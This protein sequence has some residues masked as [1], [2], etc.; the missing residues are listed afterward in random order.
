MTQI[1]FTGPEPR[2][3]HPTDAAYDLHAQ[4]WTQIPPGG[5]ALV[6]T[7]SGIALPPGTVG[8]V[9]PRS[10]LALNHGVTVLN[11]PGVIDPGYTGE[12]GVIVANFGTDVFTVEKGDRIAQLLVLATA[13]VTFARAE[14]LPPADRGPNGFGSTGT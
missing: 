1:E 2:K 3:A 13:D 12:I 9:C 7:G 10:G 6:P 8:L 4:Q 5:L 11:A 14:E